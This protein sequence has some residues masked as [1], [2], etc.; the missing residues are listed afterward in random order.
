MLHTLHDVR[1]I[2]SIVYRYGVS[3][4][5]DY[6]LSIMFIWGSPDICAFFFFEISVAYT[7]AQL[8]KISKNSVAD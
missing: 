5:Q 2:H 6:Q 3:M 1:G 4:I 7:L 8:W